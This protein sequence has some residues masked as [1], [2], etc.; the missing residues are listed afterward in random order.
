MK[1]RIPAMEREKKKKRR[2]KEKE[3]RIFVSPADIG[4][5]MHRSHLPAG[6]PLK[7]VI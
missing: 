7:L 5:Y 3:K 1:N 6:G 2:E 4:A